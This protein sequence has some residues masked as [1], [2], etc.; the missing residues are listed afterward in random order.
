M[1]ALTLASLVFATVTPSPTPVGEGWGGGPGLPYAGLHPW[2]D[3]GIDHRHP[4]GRG[5]ES[6]TPGGGKDVL[7]SLVPRDDVVEVRWQPLFD[8]KTLNGWK[9]LNGTATYTVDKGVIIGRTVKG[10]PNSFLCTEKSYADFELEYEAWVDPKINS[11]VQIRSISV[12]GY[13]NGRVHGY[14]TEIDPLERAWSGGLYDEGRRGWLNDLSKNLVARKAFKNGQWNKFRVVARGDHIQ[15]WVNGVPAADA[16]D[17]Q[18]ARGFI[19]LQV[20]QSD[21]AGLQVKFRNLR[22]K[23]L[24]DPTA[25]PPKGGKWLLKTEADLAKW[26][27]ARKAGDPCPWTWVDGA[28]EV[29]SGT[30]DAM[31]RDKFSDFD[32]HLEFAVDDNGQTGQGNGNSGL[33][34]LLSYEIQIL[35]SAPREPL[36]DEC[37]ALYGIKAPDFAMAQPAGVWQTYDLKFTAPKWDGDKKIADAR[38]TLYHNGNRVHDNVPVPRPTGAG[39]PESPL[40]RALKLQDHGHKIRFRNIWVRPR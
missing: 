9:Q 6:A 13:Q 25:N 16:R 38:V 10:S 14:Q 24:G 11:G 7:R 1:I 23:D 37:A 4:E 17:A 39:L 35:N 26:T 19:G 20:H 27:S 5:I 29:K 36:I 40:P 8:G 15:S 3:G 2:E 22:I 32:L 33:Y 21:Q 31:T 28:M 34:L 12:P 30:G 18:T